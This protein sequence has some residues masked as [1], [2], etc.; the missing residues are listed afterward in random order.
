MR[1]ATGHGCPPV[2]TAGV[3]GSIC[4]VKAAYLEYVGE[5]ASIRY[6][7]LPDPV[8]N[9]GEVLVRVQAVAVNTVDTYLRSGR[10][11]TELTFPLAVGRDLA[12]VVTAIGSGVT[13]MRVGESVWTNSA[14]YDG[15]PGATAELVPVQRRRL[16]R[17]PPAADPEYFV[18]G[19][20]PGATAHGALIGRARLAAGECVVVVGAN[21]AVGMCAVQVAASAGAEV[22]A[23]IRDL[24]SRERLRALGATH[25]VVAEADDGPRAATEAAGRTLDVLLDTTRHV[26]VG[27]VADQLNARG[28]VLVIAGQGRIGLDLW[29]FYVRE[30]QLVG[31][32][33]SA[34]TAGELEAAAEWIN[35]TYPSRPLSVSIGRVLSFEA[36]AEAQATLEAD[37]LPRMADGTVG[38]LVLTPAIRDRP[39]AAHAIGA[40][41]ATGSRLVTI[42]GCERDVLT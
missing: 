40:A 1:K 12:G 22:V 42:Q 8:P 36:A 26:D 34:M 17:L 25:V 11:S 31:F 13:D 29:S 10:W 24:R 2:L 32:V 41:A 33:M 9:A 15:R 27:G 4:R 14:G 21:G 3:L 37:R 5:D 39:D 19:V 38:R 7:E 30:L 16:Y 23:V 28:R 18:A 6:G 35:A 20:H